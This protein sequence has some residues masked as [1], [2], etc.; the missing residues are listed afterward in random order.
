M[1]L[2]KPP[3]HPEKVKQTIKD[4]KSSAANRIFFITDP[5]AEWGKRIGTLY[6]IISSV[7]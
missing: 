4:N 1:A 5:P 3:E 6:E 7:R 2:S